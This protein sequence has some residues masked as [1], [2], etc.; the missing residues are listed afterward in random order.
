MQFVGKLSVFDHF[1]GLAL[2]GFSYYLSDSLV[3]VDILEIMHHQHIAQ[4]ILKQEPHSATY[5]DNNARNQL[6]ILSFFQTSLLNEPDD[7]HDRNLDT[8]RTDL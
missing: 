5:I 1:A 7:H 6:G 8:R 4:N 3:F 2:K